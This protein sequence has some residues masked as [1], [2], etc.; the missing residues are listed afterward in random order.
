MLRF[1]GQLEERGVVLE[2]THSVLCIP[3]C[4]VVSLLGFPREYSLKHSLPN[5]NLREKKHLCSSRQPS[6][7]LNT[8]AYSRHVIKG[9]GILERNNT[10]FSDLVLRAIN[11]SSKH[12]SNLFPT[13]TSIFV[14]RVIPKK[15]FCHTKR[16]PIESDTIFEDHSSTTSKIFWGGRGGAKP[17]ATIQLG[18]LRDDDW[19]GGLET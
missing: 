7:W 19:R 18:M 10:Y 12:T 5:H 4:V 13:I 9:Y 8:S 3:S 6:L 15:S 17:G 16:Q 11:S 14:Q 2:T 1:R